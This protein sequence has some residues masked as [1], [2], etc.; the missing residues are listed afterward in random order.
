MPRAVRPDA[1]HMECV[2]ARSTHDRGRK[3]RKACSGPIAISRGNSMASIP[4]HG[5][6]RILR[7][8]SVATEKCMLLAQAFAPS[9]GGRISSPFC[10]RR[11]EITTRT[12]AFPPL[13]LPF[14]TAP[15]FA[16]QRRHQK[17]RAPHRFAPP[18]WIA[19][20]SIPSILYGIF[21]SQYI[22]NLRTP[23]AQTPENI[24]GRL[25]RTLL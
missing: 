5:N 6:R 12:Q 17:R 24:P 11:R 14:R 20:H 1:L 8:R 19:Q 7:G 4:W 21:L 16:T 25:P 3:S 18:F 2:K 13:A 9:L 15:R 23:A 22:R 10:S